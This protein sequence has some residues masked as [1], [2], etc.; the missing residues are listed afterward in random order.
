MRSFGST[1]WGVLAD[2]QPIRDLIEWDSESSLAMPF[3]DF[4]SSSFVRLVT[5]LSMEYAPETVYVLPETG[6]A[7]TS[8][9]RLIAFD[10]MNPP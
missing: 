7:V 2:R 8:M 9:L 6:L 4:A 5:V 10:E 3:P 1:D